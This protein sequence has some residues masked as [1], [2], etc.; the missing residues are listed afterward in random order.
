[1][2]SADEFID[3]PLEV[4]YD[5]TSLAPKAF[6]WRGKRFA[7]AKVLEFRQDWS[8]PAYAPHARG[9]RSRRHRNYYTVRTADGQVFELYLDHGSGRR[10]WVLSRRLGKKSNSHG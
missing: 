7:V 6:R 3:K 1:M 4:E 10:S 8:T 9:W 2:Q 5:S